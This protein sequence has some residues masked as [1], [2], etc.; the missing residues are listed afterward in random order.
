ME[1]LSLIVLLVMGTVA[2][3]INAAVGSGSLLT[4]PVLMAVGVPPGVAVRTNTVGMFF[5]TLGSCLGYRREI[6]AEK[7]H[8]APLTIT[9]TVGATAGALLLLVSPAAALDVVVPVLIVLALAMVLFQKRLTAAIRAGRERRAV[10]R[11][12]RRDPTATDTEADA[13][14]DADADA[15]TDIE[16]GTPGPRRGTGATADPSPLRSPALIGSLGAASVYGGYFTAAQGVLYL[17]ILGIFTGRSM[18]SVNSIKNLMS[19]AVNLAAAVVYVIAFFLIDAEIVWIGSA[20]IA[21]GA[22][23]GGFFG[24]H[25][26]KRMPEWLLRGI[27]VVVALAA[28]VRQVL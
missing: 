11:A 7:Q 18:G 28:L 8:L 21:L 16:T 22:L 2:G 19:L 12:E 10:Q 23:L 20:A 25:L 24:A 17:G 9:A 3:A 5:S 1:P 6:A 4:L 15:P 14:T 13:A 27:I 26:A